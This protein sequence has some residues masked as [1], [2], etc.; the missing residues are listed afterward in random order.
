MSE[1]IEAI[2]RKRL[3]ELQEKANAVQ[4]QVEEIHAMQREFSWED[5]GYKEPEWGFRESKEMPG[6]FDI[7]QKRQTVA[8]TGDPQFAMLVTDLLNR[9]R[10]E[11]LTLNRGENDGKED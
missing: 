11:E 7:C 10:L 9:A 1:D 4:E 6:A 2:R 3:K 8:L 5:F